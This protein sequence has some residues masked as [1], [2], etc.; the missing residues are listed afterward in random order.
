M[1]ALSVTPSY[2]TFNDLNGDPLDAGY[3]WI[4]T[5]GL[6]AQTN[7]IATYW[8]AA[9]TEPAV[10]PIR[11][12]GGYP[13]K[14][15]SPAMVYVNSDYSIM[16]QD[17]KFNLIYS[18]PNATER[19]SLSVISGSIPSS[20]IT[21]TPAG[22]GAVATT[23]QAKLRQIIS[24][25]DFGA[26]GNG[27]T[28]DTLAIQKTIDYL[29]SIGGGTAQFPT[30]TY[31]ISAKLTISSN[32]IFLS[33][34]GRQS[35]VIAP[36][37]MAQDFILFD[38]CSQGGVNNLGI[39]PT[40]AQTGAT[41]GIRIK[42]CHNVVVD[43]FLLYANTRNGIIVEGGGASYLCTISNFEISNCSLS[44]IEVGAGSLAQG[45]W[46]LDGIVASC[47]DGILL[48]YASGVYANTVDIISS[49]NSA[50]A[51]YPGVGQY[52]TAV[53][54][55]GVTADTSV[56]HGIA[57]IDNGGKTTD[58]NLVN[59]W[60]ATNGLSGLRCAA[61]T[62]GVLVSGSRFINND[63]RGILLENGRNYTI[64]GCQIGMNSMD[65]SALYD[66]VA[67]GAGVTHVTIENCFSGGPLGRI[68][69]LASNWQ[70]YGVWV[71]AGAD[72]LV[73]SGN[74]LTGNVTGALLNNSTASNIFI[75]ENLGD[76][77][78]TTSNIETVTTDAGGIGTITHNLGTTP[79]A[80]CITAADTAKSLMVGLYNVGPT[81]FSFYTRI[82][83][84]GNPANGQVLASGPI[85][86]SWIATKT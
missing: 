60:A 23:V 51:T 9:L 31:K 61:N 62:D 25:K 19:V 38:T 86:V 5:A 10:Q 1:S 7:P 68:G 18:A 17:S 55:E 80:V 40:G 52:V 72:Y 70:R 53:F 85:I 12:I 73:I 8:D 75:S 81:T 58:V 33:G 24:V 35:S 74:N 43:Q 28:D 83:E 66:G 14:S 76:S 57:L 39:I 79:S 13:S 84:A 20:S 49:G 45:V 64:S 82:V 29:S 59:C 36:V 30:G 27:S 50:F 65:G 56:G 46:I 2:P 67:I 22:T 47:Y 69:T 63:Q 11:T 3:I 32:S 71:G 6:A 34:E 78:K 21:Y 37:A 15:G 44:G 16:V 4:G 42:N 54:A 26:T 48:N 41:A 77:R